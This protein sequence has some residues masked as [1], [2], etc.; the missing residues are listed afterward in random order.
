MTR[1][2]Q[3]EMA[4]AKAAKKDKGSAKAANEQK[5]NKGMS[6]E[7]RMQRDADMM[8]EKQAKKEATLAAGDG[9]AKKWSQ[10]ILLAWQ[11]LYIVLLVKQTKY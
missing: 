10:T 9:K 1:G 8:R 6:K 3:R 7:A 5:A 4:R 11:F 2:N